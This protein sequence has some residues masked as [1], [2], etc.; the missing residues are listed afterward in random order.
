MEIGEWKTKNVG[1][2]D[3][4]LSSLKFYFSASLRLG[5]LSVLF[6]SA[7][8]AQS[9]P[10]EI[11]GYK[12]YRARVYV[13]SE[14]GKT[15]EKPDA[16]VK[17]GEP[18]IVDVS[19]TGVSVEISA[20]ITSAQ[21]SGTI[22]FITFKDFRVGGL[23]VSIEEYKESFSFTKNQ[24]MALPKPVKIFLGATDILR[25]AAK[26]ITNTKDEWQVTGTIFVFGRFKKFGFEF[27]R[28]VPIEINLKIKNPFTVISQQ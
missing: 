4:H 12:V 9:L 17:I 22:D 27:K 23:T 19:L 24:T 26:E 3:F 13:E 2:S 11:R 5:V 20:E 6:V 10:K 1:I 28:V 25:G 16:V 15:K 7:S 14:N 18:K 21:Q 8:L